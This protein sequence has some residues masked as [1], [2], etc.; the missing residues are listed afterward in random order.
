MALDIDD[1]LFEL[2]NVKS[3]LFFLGETLDD[4]QQTAIEYRDLK[5]NSDKFLAHDT[6]RSIDNLVTMQSIILEKMLDIE[7]SLTIKRV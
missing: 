6:D 7:K 5:K 4:I 2:N 3:L 1:A